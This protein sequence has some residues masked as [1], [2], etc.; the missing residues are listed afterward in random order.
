[1]KQ[2]KWLTCSYSQT[3][4]SFVRNK[5]SDRK[6]RLFA[7][8]C[9]RQ[10]EPLFTTRIAALS[11]HF[12]T[13]RK[14]APLVA[15]HFR[16]VVEVAERFADGLSNRKELR[17]ASRRALRAEQ[18]A[19]NDW[20]HS[21]ARAARHAADD[22]SPG[23]PHWTAYEGIEM[24]AHGAAEA[25]QWVCKGQRPIQARLLRDIVCNPFQRVVLDPS[26]PTVTHLSQ[27]IYDDRAF[28][29]CRSW[30]MRWKMPAARTRK[31]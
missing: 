14:Q 20:M 4:L 15:E 16:A 29:T 26:W 18:L 22:S 8:A 23:H 12:T 27:A 9:C 6:L 1:M 3:M 19:S 31:S 11:P 5:M 10:I 7:C 13:A 21:A 17:A 25:A 24:L 2:D 30:P 28:D